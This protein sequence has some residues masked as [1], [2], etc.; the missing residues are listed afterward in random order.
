MPDTT[1]SQLS[2]E[3]LV[4]LIPNNFDGNQYT[5]RSF[6]KQVDSVFELAEPTQ[7]PAILLFVKNKI[8]GKAREQIDV[9]CNLTTWAEISELLIKLYQCKKSLDQLLE[10]L[11]SLKQETNETV[12]QFY[13]RLEDT[14]SKVLGAVHASNA[15]ANTLPGRLSMINEITLNRFIHHTHP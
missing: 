4:K 1:T 7:I 13:Q 5:L 2:L 14:S 15:N 8:T 12:S 9:H 6:I 3:F 11:N 10:E